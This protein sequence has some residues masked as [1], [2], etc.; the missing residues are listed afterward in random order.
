MAVSNR[1]PFIFFENQETKEIFAFII[2]ALKLP[3]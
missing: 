3:D 2:S 1:L